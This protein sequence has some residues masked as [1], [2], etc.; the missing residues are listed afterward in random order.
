MEM[1][2]SHFHFQM[3]VWPFYDHIKIKMEKL[4]DIS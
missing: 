1:Q 2:S 4:F 3:L